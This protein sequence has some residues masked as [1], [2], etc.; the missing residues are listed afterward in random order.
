[1]V[2]FLNKVDKVADA[3]M[4]DI[5]E[6]EVRELLTGYEFDGKATKIVRGSALKALEGDQSE[7]GTK[8]ILNL[9]A[10]VDESIP[11]PQRDVKNPFLMP[12][13]SVFNIS[14]R[15]TVATG[16]VEQGSIRVGQDVELLVSR[17][18]LARPKSL[19]LK[20]STSLSIREKLVITL[21]SCSRVLHQRM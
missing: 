21:V 3:E 14:G 13:E 11:T 8:S 7:I 18:L 2:V 5:V 1:M 4:L 15:G 19:V 9:M 20:C 6:E 12:I 17:I 10:A 16:K